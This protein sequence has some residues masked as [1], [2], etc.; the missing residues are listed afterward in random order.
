MEYRRLGSSGLELSVISLGSWATVGERLDHE[1]SA[2]LLGTAYDLGINCFDNAET[3][4]N[5]NAEEVMGRALQKLAWPRETF[6]LSS[7][8]YWGTHQKRPNTWGLSR[9]HIVEGCHASIRRLRVDYLDI[10]LCHRY[11][12]RTPLEETVTAM[13]DLVT[14]GKVLYWGTSEWRVEQV[15]AAI[16]IA[17]DAGLVEPKLEQLQY[18]IFVREKVERDFVQL[19]REAGFGVTVWSPLAYGLLTGRY[20]KS[21]DSGGR[22]SRGEYKWLRTK[23]F[24]PNEQIRLSRIRAINSLAREIGVTPSQ[25]ALAWVL[26]NATVTTA[27][28]GASNCNQLRENVDFLTARKKIDKALCCRIDELSGFNGVES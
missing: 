15:L 2:Q 22:L 28:S 12:E 26:R 7:K 18:N 3:Y 21:L 13:S 9:K 16:R 4:G 6:V 17:K 23:F 1:G 11:D 25:L 24:G 19:N 20:D 10:F 8:V 27:I 14:Q 5:G